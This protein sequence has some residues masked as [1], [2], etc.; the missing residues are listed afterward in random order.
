MRIALV[1]D[2]NLA[3]EALKIFVR[4]QGDEVAWVAYD[5][6]QAVE[7]AASDKPDLILMDLVMPRMDGVE[8]TRKIMSNNATPI[9][10]VT[11][12]IDR[13]SSKVFE[14]LSAGALDAVD[15]P[16]LGSA[17]SSRDQALGKKIET[18]RRLVGERPAKSSR[19]P[20]SAADKVRGLK[21]LVAIGS[22]SGGPGALSAIFSDLPADFPGS[23][24]VVQHIDKSFVGGLREW[25]A[26]QTKMKIH[27]AE[28][29]QSPAVGG[30]Y[31]AASD[32]HLVWTKEQRLAY[33]AEPTKSIHRPSIDVFLDSIARNFVGRCCGA[34]LTGMG[35]DGAKG[36]LQLKDSGFL[37]LAQDQESSSIYGMPKAAAEMGAA[38]RILPL[39]Q[40]SKVLDRWSRSDSGSIRLVAPG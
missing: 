31:L 35:S 20:S 11:A 26:P 21:N 23:I 13:I 38:S 9:L 37:T 14:A 6:Q 3:V 16:I 40:F 28:D 22:S 24:V 34:I 4:Q 32:M 8:A 33:C 19:P 36:L 5:G 2:V 1:N 27:L 25:L 15:T 12:S 17:Q 30:I 18:I 29:G 39:A 7:K 10:I